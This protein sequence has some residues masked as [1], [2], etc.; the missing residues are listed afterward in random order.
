MLQC[1]YHLCKLP[2]MISKWIVL[3]SSSPTPTPQQVPWEK[4]LFYVVCNYLQNV[5]NCRQCS[6]QSIII[7][8]MNKGWKRM[9]TVLIKIYFSQELET[10]CAGYIFTIW[11][12]Y[13]CVDSSIGGSPIS[14]S[15][16]ILDDSKP[17]SSF[18]NFG[19]LRLQG[20]QPWPRFHWLLNM[21]SMTPWISPYVHHKPFVCFCQHMC[22]LYHVQAI[23]LTQICTY[24]LQT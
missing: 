21:P 6:K 11:V 12:S 14:Q 4:W 19:S 17:A 20:S 7:C 1:H 23:Q 9:N 24:Q 13:W 18:N 8:S 10:A 2:S 16:S 5:P 22:E 15:S 3:L